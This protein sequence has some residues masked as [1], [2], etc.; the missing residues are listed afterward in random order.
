MNMSL[1]RQLGLSL[2]AV[3]FAVFVGTLIL[4]VSNTRE[5]I[6]QQLSSHAQD[7]ATSFGLSIAPYLGDEYDLPLVETMLNTIFDNGYY[8]SITLTDYAG[9]ALLDKQ[10]PNTLDTVPTWFMQWFPIAAPKV[11]SEVSTGWTIAAVVTVQSNPNTGYLQLWRITVNSFVLISVIFALG[12]IL[13]LILVRLIT[14]PLSALVKQTE[15]IGEQ[16]FEPLLIQP[17]TAELKIFVN[18]FN[19]MSSSLNDLFKRLSN[20][21]ERYKQFAY[22]DELTKVGN[23]RAFDLAFDSLLS[24][25][26][27][28]PHGFLLLIRLSSLNQVNRNIGFSDGDD[29]IQSV[30]K[31]IVQL[32]ETQATPCTLY[33]LSGADFCLL[34]EDT[35]EKQ[36]VEVTQ[37]LVNQCIA[38]EKSEYERGTVH[39]GAGCFSYQDNK[40]KVLE[41]ID[42]ALTQA[43]SKEQKWCVASQINLIQSKDVWREKI[44][45]LLKA[46]QADFVAQPIVDFTHNIE[47]HE[48]FARFRDPN[49]EQYLPMGELIPVSIRL[50]FS[51]K[52][53]ELLVCCALDKLQTNTGN[54]GLN[55]SRLSVLQP[56][57]QNWLL[58]QLSLFSESCNRLILEIPERAL[59]ADIDVL[60]SFVARL[61]AL[62]VKIT[63]ERFGAQVAAFTQLRK[64][65]PDY[66]KLDGRYI[67]N[68][69]TEQDNKLFVHS[70]VSI[71]HGLNIKIIAERVETQQEAE[72]LREMQVDFIQGYLT[73]APTA[74]KK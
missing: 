25:S 15:A 8:R 30:C 48:W 12:L 61:K 38:I 23:R 44:S 68:I 11:Q 45:S 56:A 60:I 62:G 53:D 17:K 33:R 9:K 37:N 4:N 28:Q 47:Y 67:K 31:V 70:L 5:S 18:S 54:I 52:L 63:L 51:Q 43:I 26:E 16:N 73:G 42:N 27:Q 1:S 7:T 2:F 66:I 36:G 24:D 3:L 13:L 14:N 65:R 49:T 72:T 55:V 32:M 71:A 58:E 29:Y 10:N 50:D 74:I 41:R 57:F 21:T 6:E 46:Q 69:D 20:Q 34:L 19:H 59:L 39:I 64:I 40:Q 35:E 22:S